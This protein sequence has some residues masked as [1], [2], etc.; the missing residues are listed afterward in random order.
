MLVRA[1]FRRHVVAGTLL[2]AMSGC[3]EPPP[4]DPGSGG[5]AATT[6]A[7]DRDRAMR[8]TR[9]LE[10]QEAG[11]GRY[12]FTEHGRALG[13]VHPAQGIG[14]TLADGALR[15]SNGA[16]GGLALELVSVG[17]PGALEPVPE[18][19][20][21]R[22]DG[23]RARWRHGESIEAW[24]LN[25]PL[26]LEHG[27]ALAGAPAGGGPL[28]LE[29]AVDGAEVEASPEGARLR[30]AGGLV[31][32]YTDL[33]AHDA[34]GVPLAATMEVR[35]GAIDLVVDDAGA[36]YP[37]TIDPLVWAQATKL[38]ASNGKANEL[39]GR[40]VA[41]SGDR[42]I[43]GAEAGAYL[44][45][46]NLVGNWQE[47]ALVA[48]SYVRAVGISGD[49][50]VVGSPSAESKGAAYVYDRDGTGSWKLAAKLLSD[51][52]FPEQF[53]SAVAVSGDRVLVGAREADLG[54]QDA[55]AAYVF[56][57]DGAGVWSKVATLTSPLAKALD[58]FGTAVALSGDYALVGAPDENLVTFDEGAAHV[59][60]RSVAG[61]WGYHQKL[62]ATDMANQSYFGTSVAIA[63]GR[64]VVGA[65]QHD[66][67]FFWDGAAYVFELDGAFFK[68]KAELLAKD[69][70]EE[71]G[72][73]SSVAID[74]DRAVAGAPYDDDKGSKSGSAYVFER[75]GMGVWKQA[76]KLV[77]ADGAPDD[78][79]GRSVALSGQRMLA[80]AEQDDD[81]GTNSGAAY[82][83]AALKGNGDACNAATECASG[84]CADGVCCNGACA[85]ACDAC[86]LATSKGTCK[87]VAKGSAGSPSC[88]PYLC[89]GTAAV[90]PVSCAADADCAAGA[91]CSGGACVPKSE[92]GV[93]CAKSSACQSGFCVDGVCCDSACPGS[94][95]A[96]NVA[97]S[98][99]ACVPAPKGSPGS[100]SCGAYLCDGVTSA[101]SSKCSADA[102]CSSGAYCAGTSCVPKKIN[103]FKCASAKECASGHCVDG[104]C[105][106]GACEG[107]CNACDLVGKK[108]TCALVSLGTPGNPSCTPY[109]CDGASIACPGGCTADAGCQ[110]GHYCNGGQCEK[111]LDLG[112]ACTAAS[113]CA[114]GHCVDGVC[115]D[116]ACGAGNDADCQACSVAKGGA[117]DG[118]CSPLAAGTLCR[119]AEGACDVAESCDGASGACPADAFAKA[120][121]E[122]RAAAGACDVAENCDG[123]SGACPADAFAKAGTEC[124]AA[125]GACDVAESCDGASG[126]CP[127]DAAMPDGASC[128]DGDACTEGD[129]CQSGVCQSGRDTCGGE[130]GA[131]GAGVGASVGAGGGSSS[132][133]TAGGAE[134]ST[135]RAPEEGADGCGCRL[136]TRESARAPWLLVALAALVAARRRRARR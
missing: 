43:V 114:S 55:G 42:A 19:A 70:A 71:D 93:A 12:A 51:A 126:A 103:S 61:V 65:P 130:G 110:S 79:L 98:L 6:P 58:R 113:V 120:G 74:G 118:V 100:P 33:F 88:N 50:A 37:V 48:P 62:V 27:F 64:I 25:G 82:D 9:I 68:P 73:G 105:C 86:N 123:A 17:R 132:S 67:A 44:F 75:D 128:D 28:V 24:W 85:G 18:A 119:A 7:V 40:K 1:R 54:A 3:G 102:D 87:L 60:K 101:C 131:G 106:D 30:A 5:A 46:R 81:K 89:N 125:A 34:R 96:C 108:G 38:V 32:E 41:L 11:D 63:P 97:G 72:L 23:A 122:C 94:C 83:F 56:E 35:A 53:G 29:L 16:G 8:A 47:V 78:R 4:V 107:A 20:E 90:C 91:W 69:A 84:F 121:T 124:R 133:V 36:L 45:E 10:A 134:T 115:C 135:A 116:G 104:V 26:G 39:F 117:A 14:F 112:S 76:A 77:A 66:H 15:I 2:L 111:K 95:N 22:S 57:R 80:G 136:A 92:L 59:F 129:A 49:R 52:L 99:G 21:L 31:V 13:A 109:A 127:P